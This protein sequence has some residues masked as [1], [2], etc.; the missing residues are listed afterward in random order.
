[1]HQVFISAKELKIKRSK[2]TTK[3]EDFFF[4]FWISNVNQEKRNINKYRGKN[5]GDGG[6]TYSLQ[7]AQHTCQSIQCKTGRKRLFYINSLN[8][9]QSTQS[10]MTVPGGADHP[11]SNESQLPKFSERRH[12]R[13]MP[14]S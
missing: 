13:Y 6:K 4:F 14:S 3:K 8:T 10:N 12:S 7:I 2:E 1:L 9:C 11:S 5:F